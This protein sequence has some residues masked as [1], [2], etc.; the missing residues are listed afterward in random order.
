MVAEP[1]IMKPTP[2]TTGLGERASPPD[3]M[4]A[5][6]MQRGAA[7]DKP[8]NAVDILRNALMQDIGDA[9]QVE[10]AIAD[11][12]KLAL[13]GMSGL[14]QIGNTV[15][16][17]NRFDANSRPLPAATAEVHMF[18][19]EPL[20]VIGQRFIAVANTLRELGYKQITS[21][22]PE[23]GITRIL[24]QAAGPAKAQVRVKQDVQNMNGEMQPVYRIEVIL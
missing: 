10:K 19:E 22:S 23:P 2:P 1:P 3:V 18:T 16:L 20:Q 15:F 24:Q 17:V 7:P 5:M 6:Q 4:G 14:I 13:A 8:N 11:L 21:F 9:Q 12:D